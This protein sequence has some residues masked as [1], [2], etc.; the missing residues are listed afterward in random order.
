M[1]WTQ[2]TGDS[3]AYFIVSDDLR[4]CICKSGDPPIYTLARLGG[5]HAEL[6]MS[7]SLQAC[8]ERAHEPR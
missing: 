1:K 6:V 8:K 3:A 2:G 7:G 5:K 4:W